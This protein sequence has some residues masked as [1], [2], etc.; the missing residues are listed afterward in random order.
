MLVSEQL[1]LRGNKMVSETLKVKGRVNLQ[2]L[3]KDNN[4]KE[5][6][7]YNNLV[8]A[9]GKEY[10]SS[11]ML[12]NTDPVM[13]HMAIGSANVA[14][15]LGQTLL[16]GETSRV[17]L[18]TPSRSSNTITYSS[19]FGAGSGTGTVSE[20]GIFNSGNTTANTGTM[21][22]RVNFNEVYKAAS[23]IIVIT[24]NVTVE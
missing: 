13:S 3:D 21:L 11:R 10:I 20:A 8:V 7:E 23:D 12:A 17:A 19:T 9:I 16:L 22:C 15:S 24:W 6:R 18:S 2:L 14:A 4:I 5:T 1:Q